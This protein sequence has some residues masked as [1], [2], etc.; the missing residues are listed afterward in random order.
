MTYRAA[1]G[2]VPGAFFTFTVVATFVWGGLAVALRIMLSDDDDTVSAKDLRE[3]T[4]SIY[5]LKES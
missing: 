5:D 2:S 1:F 3:T 4:G